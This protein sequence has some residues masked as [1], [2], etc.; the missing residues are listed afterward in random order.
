[1]EKQEILEAALF[2]AHQKGWEKTSV[3][4]ISK[5]IGYST[6]K[7]YSEFDGK[8]GLYNAIQDSGFHLLKESYLQAIAGID[9]AETQLIQLSK[10]HFRFALEHEKYY[11]LMFKMGGTNCEVKDRNILFNASQPVRDAIFN[12]CGKVDRILFFNWWVIAH[13]FIVI[14]G[15][16]HKMPPEEA[17]KMLTAMVENFIKAIKL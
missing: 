4:E 9:N 3:R 15:S 7:I 17:E 11:E 8:D 1:M 5:H 13:G 6:I 10:A 16:Q 12:I 14:V 2:I